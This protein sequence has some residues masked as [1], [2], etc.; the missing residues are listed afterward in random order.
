M[1]DH[2]ILNGLVRNVSKNYEKVYLFVAEH[3]FKSVSFMYRDLAN[4]DF[5]IVSND[6]DA[7]SYIRDRRIKDITKIGFNNLDTKNFYFDEAFYNQCGI[8]FSYRWSNFYVKRDHI[9]EKILFEKFDIQE[10]SYVF[11]HDDKERGF[12]INLDYIINKNLKIIYP[13]KGM[14]DNIFDYCYLLENAAEIHC[15]DS[16]FKLLID[17]LNPVSEKIY[18]HLYVRGRDNNHI[19]SSKLKWNKIFYKSPL[20]NKFREKLSR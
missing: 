17:S 19:S 13:S 9:S 15:M 12:E 4:I 2:I 3:N 8:D 1:G 11:I 5:V 18:Y 20:L 10:K 6:D 14:T 16:S 7:I